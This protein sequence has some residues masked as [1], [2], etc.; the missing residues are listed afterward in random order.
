MSERRPF[1]TPGATPFRAAVERRS[2]HV[3]V[4]LRGLP[5]PLPGLVVVGLVAAGLLAPPV[6]G[7]VALLLVAVLLTWLVFLSWPSVPP[8]GRA[9]RVVVVALVIAYALVR[10]AGT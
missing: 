9:I 5:R 8:P 2:A 1:L 7:G 10:L 3:V 4:F 6:V